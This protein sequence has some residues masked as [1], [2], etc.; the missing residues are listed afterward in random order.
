MSYEYF[1]SP[2]NIWILAEDTLCDKNVWNEY[3]VYS[4]WIDIESYKQLL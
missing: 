4:W 3:V 1:S 2:M